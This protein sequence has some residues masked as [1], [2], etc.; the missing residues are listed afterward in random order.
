MNWKA[1]FIWVVIITVIAGFAGY[2]Y[3]ENSV[4]EAYSAG[5]N[6]K[7]VSA[8]I[9]IAREKFA[10]TKHIFDL[11]YTSGYIDG[12]KKT[13]AYR[14]GYDTGYYEGYDEGYADAKAGY[15]KR[16]L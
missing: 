7:M 15:P 12:A 16:R 5:W 11:G 14:E 9:E 10:D 13:N 3:H 8:S 4:E 2:W 6:D 1:A